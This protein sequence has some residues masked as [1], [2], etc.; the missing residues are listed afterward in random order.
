MNTDD[1]KNISIKVEGMTCS[2]CARSVETA[3]SQKGGENV[4]VSLADKEVTFNNPNDIDILEF[5]EQIKNRGYEVIKES[6]SGQEEKK[7]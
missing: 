3:I 4:V 2:G 6:T 1:N 5:E 7:N